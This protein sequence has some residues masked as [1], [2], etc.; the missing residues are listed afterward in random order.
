MLKI[1]Y[2][3]ASLAL[4]FASVSYS[5]ETEDKELISPTELA[6]KSDGYKIIDIRQPEEFNKGHVPGAY[7]IPL[8]EI[9]EIQLERQGM[10]ET[11]QIVLYGLSET[12]AKKAKMLLDIIGYPNVRI[13][14]G[15]YTH[16]LEDGHEAVSGAPVQPT[17]SGKNT[18]AS[19]VLHVVPTSYDFGVISKV[20]GVVETTFVIENSSDNEVF[21][22]E[23]TTSCGCTT[24]TMEETTIPAGGNRKLTV[25]FDPDFHKEPEGKFSRTVF[26]QTSENGEILAKIEV[27]IED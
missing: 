4:L 19:S 15:G 14:A 6:L 20:D 11:D 13:L 27:E 1:P 21:I 10:V 22:T 7:S 17:A 8:K 9:S 12:P 5:H 16:W 25:V 18:D 3:L 23:I 26:L 2:I 24:G